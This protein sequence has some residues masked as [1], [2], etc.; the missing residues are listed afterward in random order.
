MTDVEISIMVKNMAREMVKEM[1]AS[2]KNAAYRPPF[3]AEYFDK[4]THKWI[5][6]ADG[7]TDEQAR[8]KRKE[9]NATHGSANVRLRD[10]PITLR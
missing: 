9:L 10:R 8:A 1:R 6:A 2:V 5:V 4:K 7:L 3:K